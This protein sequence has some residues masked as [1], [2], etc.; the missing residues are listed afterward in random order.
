MCLPKPGGRTCACPHGFNLANRTDNTSSLS[1]TVGVI[2]GVDLG[3]G[4]GFASGSGLGLANDQES[5][6][7]QSVKGTQVQLGLCV[8]G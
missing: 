6:S 3:S 4:S 7:T 8:Q 2:R 5:N 1:V